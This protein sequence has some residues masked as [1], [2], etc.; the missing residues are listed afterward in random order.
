MR[1]TLKEKNLT[2]LTTHSHWVPLLLG[3]FM[4]GQNILGRKHVLVQSDSLH[5]GQKRKRKRGRDLL[6][7]ISFSDVSQ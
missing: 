1:E 6:D 5:G 3:L 4:E 2:R 7:Q